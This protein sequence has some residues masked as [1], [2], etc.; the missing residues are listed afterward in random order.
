MIF[1]CIV[2]CK[3]SKLVRMTQM[4]ESNKSFQTLNYKDKILHFVAVCDD[5]MM[6]IP[7]GWGNDNGFLLT[8]SLSWC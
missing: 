3:N 8:T 4:N 6:K 7:W 5:W 1:N 2:H